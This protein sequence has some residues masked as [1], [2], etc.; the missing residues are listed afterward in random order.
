MLRRFV[1][2]LSA[3]LLIPA[4]A[5][6][7]TAAPLPGQPESAISSPDQD[8]V[9]P[10]GTPVLI[11]GTARSSAPITAVDLSFDG[12]QT[13]ESATTSDTWWAVDHT[14]TTP[15][16]VAVLSRASTA[17][18]VQPAP[19]P[20]RHFWVGRGPRAPLNCTT[21]SLRLPNRVDTTF[22]AVDPDPRPVELGTRF[23]VDRPGFITGVDSYNAYDQGEGVRLGRLWT[24]DGE[25]LG[26]ATLAYPWSS[27]FTFPT[28][29]PVQPGVTYVAGHYVPW[30]HYPVTE[31]YFAAAVVQ[32]PFVVGQ[33]AGV[34]RYADDGSEG[35][36]TESYANSHY[37]VTPVFAS[38]AGVPAQDR[39]QSSISSP[40]PN[41][42]LPLGSPVLVAGSASYRTWSSAPE[43]QITGVDVS[44]DAGQTW[45]SA[46]VRGSFSQ[47]TW[48]T[49]HT[50]TSPGLASVLTRASSASDVQ[51]APFPQQHFWIGQGPQALLPC[52]SC[53]LTLPG[54]A[55]TTF[56]DTAADPRPVEVGTRFQVDR[57]GVITG[58]R[59]DN[60]HYPAEG[61]RAV[62]LW[63]ADGQLLGEVQSTQ[64]SLWEF[65]FTTP[66]PVQPGITYV[67][68]HYTPWGR[69]PVIENYFTAA[70][71]QAP[72]VTA[73][74]AGVYR[75]AD[76]GSK[77][78]PTESFASSSYLVT[79][80]FG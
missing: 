60:R 67:A 42:V 7:A 13:W 15:G 29:I 50:F 63:T 30:G 69:Y 38:P 52:T 36:P 43:K 37:S 59:A 22:T 18:G 28:P 62:R 48:S 5:S 34:Y 55:D 79:P 44:F 46:A 19:F 57:P 68:T 49:T 45:E 58:I 64:T 80:V 32:A 71:V 35:V 14:F 9:L 25:L 40:G 26:E 66:I 76:D 31:N 27:T 47:A 20:Q 17:T 77:E 78:V 11:T 1:A 56:T 72:F 41:N 6:P 16:P 33:G 74:N 10:L 12:G 8:S 21:C 2:L 75:Y 70:V 23:Q 53:A 61:T 4:T 73:P 65:T 24:A 54:R 51:P 39:V 3:A